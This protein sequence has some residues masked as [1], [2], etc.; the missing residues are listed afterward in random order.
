[1]NSKKILLVDDEKSILETLSAYFTKEKM[2]VLLAENGEEAIQEFSKNIPDVIILDWMIPK[3]SGPEVLREIR[4]GSNVPVLML[5]ARDDES[6]II[7]GLE[8]GADDYVT[9]PFSPREVVARVKSLLRRV[10]TNLTSGRIE[11][12]SLKIDFDKREIL[13]NN[14]EILLTPIEFSIL[15]ELYSH[16]GSVVTRQYL[17]EH[18]IGFEDAV[19]DRTLDTHIK[20]LRK[21]I[22]DDH[23]NPSIINTIRGIGFKI[24]D[25]NNKH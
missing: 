13:K 10:N 22:E 25:I 4:Q 5:T 19:Y 17:M 8:L 24:K 15:K 6:D 12:N 20:N 2:T 3:K 9:K 1:M 14:H 7:L 18:V 21:K 23:K 11:Y 16:L